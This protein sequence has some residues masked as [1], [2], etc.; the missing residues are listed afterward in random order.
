MANPDVLIVG[1]G[2]AGLCCARQLHEQGIA[3][4]IL[5]MSDDVGGRVRSDTVEGFQLDRGFQVLLTAYPE[6][7]RLLDYNALHLQPFYPGAVVRFG[8]RFHRVADPW[9]RPLDGLRSIFSPIGTLLDKYR[10][11]RLRFRVRSGSLEALFQRPETS[12]LEA[13]QRAG[14]SNA[15]IERFFRPFFGGVFLEANLNTSSRM[16]EFVFRMFSLGDI[17]IPAGGMGAISKQLAAALP[18]PSIRLQA[19]VAALEADSVILTSGERLQARA[20]VVATEGAAAAR[21]IDTLPS[22]SSNRVTCLYFVAE[23]PPVAEP[24]LMLNGEG[25]G[26]VNNLCVPSVVA[27]SYA[28]AG[29]ALVAATVLGEPDLEDAVLEHAVRDQL[30]GWFGQ[31]VQQWRHLR[32]YRI[33]HALPEQVPPTGT[34]S[35]R[36]VRIRP[37]LY[38]CGDHRDIASIQGA[39]LSGR[40]AAEAIIEDFNR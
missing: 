21:L 25:N 35:D 28:P 9:R 12:T 20:A 18:E 26:L 13:L 10:V 37:G 22:P 7:K 31:A 24:V 38:I 19:E 30:T 3:C 15:M 16:L 8:G 23:S 4:Q 39:M 34:I 36:S 27:P 11:A 1:A 6:A 14:F 29:A 2:L 32:T 40:R 17:A 5:E 33:E